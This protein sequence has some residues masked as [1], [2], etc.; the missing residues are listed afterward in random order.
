[1]S[2]MGH[3]GRSTL[4]GRQL[5][6]GRRMPRGIRRP[7][8]HQQTSFSSSS[9][10]PWSQRQPTQRRRGMIASSTCSERSPAQRAVEASNGRLDGADNEDVI[11]SFR[12]GHVLC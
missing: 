4:Q 12:A 5:N 10:F 9:A 6:V 8:L 2:P 1:M 11:L 3:Q 7:F